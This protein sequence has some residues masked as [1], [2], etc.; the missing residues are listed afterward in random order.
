MPELWLS[1]PLGRDRHHEVFFMIG[2]LGS[3]RLAEWAVAF[4]A[5]NHLYFLL[6]EEPGLQRRFGAEYA[7]Y[8]RNVP[9]WIPRWRAWSGNSPST[10]VE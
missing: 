3:A 9:R 1:I 5:I 4:F 6:S 10:P 8:R 2:A 7:A